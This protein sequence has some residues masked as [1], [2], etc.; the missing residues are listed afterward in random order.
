MYAFDDCSPN[1]TRRVNVDSLILIQK[2]AFSFRAGCRMSFLA[3]Q[4]DSLS[5]VIVVVIQVSVLRLHRLVNSPK[6]NERKCDK[7]NL[8]IQLETSSD[9]WKRSFFTRSIAVL[10]KN[11]SFYY[12]IPEYCSEYLVINNW[13]NYKVDVRSI[14][15]S[16]LRDRP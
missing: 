3:R 10:I 2:R 5:A 9:S 13:P 16:E 15:H 11:K 6:V 1:K 12:P 14:I 7:E 8:V 4:V